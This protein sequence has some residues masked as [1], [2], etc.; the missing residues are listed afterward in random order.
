[1]SRKTPAKIRTRDQGL[2]SL[3]S[4][5]ASVNRDAIYDVV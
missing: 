2:K 1:L 3:T 4:E 5:V